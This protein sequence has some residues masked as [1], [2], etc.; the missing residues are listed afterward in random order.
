M[1]PGRCWKTRWDYRICSSAWISKQ[2]CNPF[3]E[4]TT[5]FL[6]QPW[7]IGMRICCGFFLFG[8]W[9]VHASVSQ[10]EKKKSDHW[11]RFAGFSLDPNAWAKPNNGHQGNL[12]IDHYQHMHTWKW[13]SPRDRSECKNGWMEEQSV[14][15]QRSSKKSLKKRTQTR[16]PEGAE[17]QA[18]LASSVR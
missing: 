3:V 5:Q 1:S 17:G 13:C 10:R 6:F 16:L 8:M 12:E 4:E 14:A 15:L 7:Q 2:V 9:R 11:K 18:L